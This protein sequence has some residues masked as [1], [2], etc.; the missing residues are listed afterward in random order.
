MGQGS[1]TRPASPADDRVV[2]DSDSG[3]DIRCFLARCEGKDGP[4]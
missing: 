2:G 3:G 1:L 4:R